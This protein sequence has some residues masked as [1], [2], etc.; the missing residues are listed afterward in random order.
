MYDVPTPRM[1]SGSSLRAMR[2]APTG[3]SAL[4]DR[5]TFGTV[6]MGMAARPETMAATTN[7]MLR[8]ASAMSPP[9]AGPM[10][11]PYRGAT[12]LAGGIS[13]A[14]FGIPALLG[15][16]R[17]GALADGFGAEERVVG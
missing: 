8:L 10:M 4:R 14:T 3:A 2:S 11:M 1:M 15:S 6:A 7:T 16:A 5:R 9:M 13:F 17:A 12:T